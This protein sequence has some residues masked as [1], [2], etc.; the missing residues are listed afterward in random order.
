[1][2][3][4]NSDPRMILF[5]VTWLRHFFDI[6]EARLVLSLYL[7]EGLDLVAANRYWS[8]VTGI[9]VERFRKPYRAAPDPSIRTAKHVYGCPSVRYASASTHQAVM[10]IVHAL[11]NRT[12]IPG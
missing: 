2:G 12:C 11:L 9:P 7:H 5:F 1:M 3:F 4:A 6:D 10:G 8:D